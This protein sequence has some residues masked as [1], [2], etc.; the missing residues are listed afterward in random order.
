MT[1]FNKVMRFC[2]T[3]Q[4]YE[5]AKNRGTI[6]DDLFV[7][8]LQ[9]KLAKFQG[10][11][12]D[13]S[14]NADL[15]ALATKGELEALA[16][17]IASNE[18]VWA[19]A[20]N[21]L[22]DRI[23]N[24]GTGV[25]DTLSISSTNPIQNR[26]VSNALSTKADSSSLAMVATSGSYN[27][28]SNKPAIPSE[29]TESTVSGWGFTKNT[30]TYSKPSSGIPKSDLAS[31]VQTS[32]GKADTALQS[33]TEQYKG[34]VTG[35]K[36]NGTTKNPSNGV[37]DLGTVIT[38]HQDISGKQDTLV[39]GTNI[40]TVNGESILG[41]G[42][43][44]ISV[45]TVD[46]A[47]SSTSTN[48][49]QNKVV[50]AELD[51]KQDGI[52][53]L[54]TIR[55]GAAKGATAVQP[56]GLKTV[57]GQS[58]VGTGN[59]EIK[60]D[61]D[62]EIVNNLTDG[63][64]DKA[65][66]AEQGK[67]LDGGFSRLSTRLADA[68]EKLNGYT[69]DITDFSQ[70][71][72][73][74]LQT[75]LGKWTSAGNAQSIL[76]PVKG[77]VQYTIVGTSNRSWYFTFLKS[78][79]NISHGTAA[80]LCEL[81]EIANAYM[82]PG[83]YEVNPGL[84]IVFVAPSDC[85]YLTLT[86]DINGTDTTPKSITSEASIGL[87]ERVDALEKGE[88]NENVEIVFEQG[89][90]VDANGNLYDSDKYIRSTQF[91]PC[92][93]IS[94]IMC[95]EKYLMRIFYYDDERKFIKYVQTGSIA[96]V[97]SRYKYFK[98]R[99]G[100][101]VTP[102]DNTFFRFIERIDN[103]SLLARYVGPF[104]LMRNLFTPMFSD[105]KANFINVSDT[106]GQ[107]ES[108]E[109]AGYVSKYCGKDIIY[110]N[111]GDM[112]YAG[113]KKNGLESENIESYMTLA[114]QF[115]IYHCVGQHE[116]GIHNVS[117]GYDGKLIANCFSH[118]EVFDKFIEPMLPYWGLAEEQTMRANK[119]IY[120][121]KDF[122][123]QKIRLISLYQFNVPLDVN[124]SDTA[125]YKYIRGVLWYGQNQI[126]WLIDKLNTAPD[127]YRIV[128]LLHEAEGV[129]TDSDG[130][131]SFSKENWSVS[132]SNSIMSEF[133][134]R[135][136]VDAFIARS[137]LIKTYRGERSYDSNDNADYSALQVSVNADFS[138]AKAK[139]GMYFMG[140]AHIDLVGMVESTQKQ[141]G[142]CTTSAE[143]PF[144][145]VF[146]IN[147]KTTFVTGYSAVDDFKK[148]CIGRIGADT[149]IFMQDRS[150]DNFNL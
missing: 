94:T 25:D 26:V 73:F 87:L 36:I 110:I 3:L 83:R 75:L 62:I 121:Y 144:D 96:S 5:S 145:V 125:K 71:E 114:K 6:T 1:G 86:I 136:I 69:L 92:S 55:S 99:I 66:S 20:L 44:S 47:F 132:A 88:I 30:G 102:S 123:S 112:L 35:V 43:I 93:S 107:Y 126:N 15:T 49:V 56:E 39:S 104:S 42:N 40:K 70:F 74:G 11:T 115:E 64:V 148:F 113:P 63:G 80:D 33:Y 48:A 38:A 14:E 45:P 140:D 141:F 130:K 134:V 81:G 128:L 76:I 13:W 116:V 106:H 133:P 100:E 97:D 120:Y 27:D 146:G 7:V 82:H 41:E 58:I 12:F 95:S 89:T 23:N 142:V 108:V 28:L 46:A 139:F 65:L 9:D 68:E 150:K 109:L 72:R 135:D 117:A 53:D 32:L 103:T 138:N 21:D 57:N 111:T 52:S 59:I 2:N 127:G 8:I 149:S 24:I 18:R 79:D 34:T 50:K 129:L 17:E 19:E 85:K 54:E 78:S 84:T 101:Y 29:V 10:Q 16:E 122:D 67:V 137:T 31:A 77:N 37:V 105:T 61:A 119:Q 51:K 60:A 124:P 98:V 118:D 4:D 91:I 22:N 143:S 90:L 131:S 147:D